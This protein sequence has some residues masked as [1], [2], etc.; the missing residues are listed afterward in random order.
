[1][2]DSDT[3]VISRSLAEPEAFTAI[4]DRHAATVHRYLGRRVGDL[5][6]DL[7]GETFLVA[8]RRRGD[9]RSGHAEA[10]PWLLG[11]ATNLVRRH[12]RDEQRRYR[13]LSRAAGEHGVAGV[14]DPDDRLAAEALRPALAD[15][16][17]AIEPR[18]RDVLLLVAWGGLSYDEI[19][20]VLAIPVGTVRSRLNR[21]RRRTSAVLADAAPTSEEI[22]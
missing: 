5:A 4:F 2:D 17:A 16:L 1:M 22:R 21:A 15:A 12:V 20:T 14:A 18:D 6:D 11:I 10:R 8:F 13:A 3:E 7:L 19:A 9:Y